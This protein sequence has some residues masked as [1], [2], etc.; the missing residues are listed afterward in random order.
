MIGYKIN[1]ICVAF[2][3][4]QHSHNSSKPPTFP[5]YDNF[6]IINLFKYPHDLLPKPHMLNQAIEQHDAVGQR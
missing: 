2:V 6:A 3:I 5:T 1:I 4:S